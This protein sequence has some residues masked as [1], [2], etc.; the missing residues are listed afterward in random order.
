MSGR[1]VRS[2]L[3]A[4]FGERGQRLLNV[5][6]VLVVGCGGLGSAAASYLAAAGVGRL[7]IVDC[8]DVDISNLQRQ[9][10]YDTSQV[11]QRKVSCAAARL[12]ALNP[13]IE[14]IPIDMRLDCDN[15]AAIASDCSL[16]LDC[17]DNY[18]A[19]YDLSK[20]C[21]QHSKPLLYATAEG[22]TGQ[23][24]LFTPSHGIYYDDLYPYPPPQLPTVGVLSPTPGVI[25]TIEASEAVK[26][27]AG[28][29]ETLEG[30][31]LKIDLMTMQFQVFRF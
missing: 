14:I 10:L 16:V 5:S 1:Y 22:M 2:E 19:R 20:M 11:G 12:R 21:R 30:R 15:F 27:L 31:L 17:T 8:D 29:G 9:I 4:D 7:V 3:F 24:A 6:S 18:K 23:V 25:G 28:I 26:Y 13:E